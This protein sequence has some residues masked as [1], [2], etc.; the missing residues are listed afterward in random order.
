MTDNSTK[1]IVVIGAGPGGYPAAFAAADLGF[2]VTVVD[3]RQTP[4]GVCLQEGCIPSK[5]LLH[6]SRV[7]QEAK[8]AAKW[9][10]TFESPKIDLETLRDWKSSVM[11]SL[12]SGIEGLGK[13]RNVSFISGR[14]KFLNSECIEI[15]DSDGSIVEFSYDR[16]IVAT[17]ST[18]VIPQTLALDDPRV[19]DSTQALKL[20]DIPG[21]LLVIGGG[22]I[23]LELGSVYAAL[24]SN[25]TVVEMTAGLLQG[26]D[27]ELVRPLKKHLEALFESIHLKTKV[28]KM[29]AESDG[30]LV[31]LERPDGT[32][33]ELYDR[34]LVSIGRRPNSDNLGLENTTVELDDHGF[35]IVDGHCR[36]SDDKI[37][38]VGDIAG[39]PMLAHKATREAKIAVATIAEEKGTEPL[40]NVIPAVIFTDPEIAWC[41]LTETVA[42]ET[43]VPVKSVRYPWAASGRAQAVDAADGM[44]KI[45]F[46]PETSQVLG[47]GI[48][49]LGAGELIAEGVLAVEQGLQALDL[50]DSIHPHPT[51][52]ETL[53]EASE[54]FLGQA[55]HLYR[56]KR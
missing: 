28:T 54:A 51:L 14:A 50:A 19:L 13:A 8:R 16:A 40:S 36:T 15:T 6:V 53:M 7:I 45:I 25:V 44:T 42:K 23:G 31:E 18:P 24:G 39:Q 11:Q 41:G 29:T 33:S 49:G 12:T 55:T 21:K 46:D 26:V 56:K 20:Q 32:H 2:D 9:G 17:G 10:V 38:A 27:R 52:S 34:V 4:G 43:G 37:F 30:I 3:E 22:Y 48:V 5:T 35:I 1:K 47:V